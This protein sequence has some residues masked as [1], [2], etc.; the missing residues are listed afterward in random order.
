M[1]KILIALLITLCFGCSENSG[2][3]NID[4]G[5]ATATSENDNT[6]TSAAEI[7]NPDLAEILPDL[8]CTECNLE[9]MASAERMFEMVT[10]LVDGDRFLPD[11]QEAPESIPSNQI[12]IIIDAYTS[13]VNTLTE[14]E[15]TQT[16]EAKFD[17]TVDDILDSTN[18]VDPGGQSSV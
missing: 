6:S 18:N 10:A 16:T 7:V 8:I 13:A 5:G 2:D 15:D 11:G 12:S 9:Q 14:G 17:D 4:T 3:I 1:K